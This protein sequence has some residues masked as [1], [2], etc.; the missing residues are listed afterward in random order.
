MPLVLLVEDDLSI[1]DAVSYNLEADGYEVLRAADGI[2]A[3][4]LARSEHPDLVVLDVMLPRMSGLDVCRILRNEQTVPILML[5]ARTGEADKIQGLDLGADDYVT[6]PFS[7]REL[8]ARVASLLR[9]DR[10]SRDAGSEQRDGATVLSGA[11]ITLDATRH[12]VERDGQPVSL[13][14]REFE[15]LEFLMRHPGQALT[16]ELILSGVWGFSYAGETRTVDVHIRW[17]REKLESDPAHPQHIQTVRGVGYK[18]V[19]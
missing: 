3:L 6:K 5:T 18:F 11:N 19:P 4:E 8:R 7:M 17:L 2:S 12:E 15:L 9:R 14:P 10:L 16:R 1:A 13:R